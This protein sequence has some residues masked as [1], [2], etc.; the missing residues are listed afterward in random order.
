[1]KSVIR[2]L[3]AAA[4]IAG[5]I[6]QTPRAA[7]ETLSDAL[8]AA[9]LNS[10]LLDQNRAL[11]RAADEDVAQ[12]I[13][14]LR[15]V[16]AWAA[17]A[18]AR[19]NNTFDTTTEFASFELTAQITIYD[20]GRTP[21]AIKA[22]KETVLAIRDALLELEQNVLLTTVRAYMELI[23]AARFVDLR[24]NNVRL[25][26][27]ELRAAQDRFAVGDSTRTDVSIAEARLA[28][29]K[30]ALAAAEGDFNFAREEYLAAVGSYPH[31]IVRPIAPSLPVHSVEEAIAIAMKRRPLILQRQH[32]VTVAEIN[33]ARARANTKPTVTGSAAINLDNEDQTPE[34]IISLGIGQTI[35]QGGAL[36]SAIRQ[37]VARAEAERAELLQAVVIVKQEVA[38]AWTQ[39]RVAIASTAASQQQ[40]RA[41]QTAFEG[42]RAEAELGSRTTLDVLDAEQEL[43]D[44][45]ASLIQSEVQQFVAVYTLLASMGLLT[46]DHLNLGIVT[47]DPDAY[48]SSVGHAPVFHNSEQGEKL[49]RVLKSLGK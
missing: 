11:L 40:V 5:S 26:T 35:Y 13:A 20:F 39:L 44:A 8:V 31:N 47:Y 15:P 6:A 7:A 46:V 25:I 19:Y 38:N 27:V 9:Y 29:A 23:R 48:Y 2:T 18:G 17:S 1:M 34:G 42:V 21:L 24:R 22:T 36:Q 14:T 30:A 41:S 32:E 43:L 10:N 28:A 49:D 33:I 45:R 3:F 16:I 37:S 12:A 4:C